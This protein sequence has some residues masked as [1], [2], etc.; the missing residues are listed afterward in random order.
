[1]NFLKKWILTHQN[2]L[3]GIFATIAMLMVLMVLADWLV[4]PLYTQHAREKELPD[5]T[6]MSMAEARRLLVENGFDIVAEKSIYDATY[7]ESTVVQQNPAAYSRVKNGRRVYVTLSAGEKLVQVPRVIGESERDA[8][9]TL[10]QSGLLLGDVYYEYHDYHLRGVVSEQSIH[11]SLEV[12]ENT[13][14][15]ITVSLG[16]EPHRFQVP[17]VVGKSFE[18]ARKIILKSGLEVGSISFVVKREYVPDTVIEQSL[19][20]GSEVN[21][22]ST[23]NLVVSRLESMFWQ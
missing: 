6:E 14:I 16:R 8:E 22:G 11:A 5:V 21:Q 3:K 13:A 19:K 7:P 10:K 17:D 9:F 18:E 12:S 15:D 1:M 23:I 2:M 20:S 4:M